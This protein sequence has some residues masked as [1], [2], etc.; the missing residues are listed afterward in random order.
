MKKQQKIEFFTSSLRSR[1][2]PVSLFDLAAPSSMQETLSANLRVLIVSPKALTSG[3]MCT[4]IN[5]FACPPGHYMKKFKI[6]LSNFF[7][8]KVEFIKKTYFFIFY[9]ESLVTLV[10]A[11]CFCKEYVCSSG[12]ERKW[13]LRAPKVICWCIALPLISRQLPRICPLFHFQPSP[14]DGGNLLERSR[15]PALFLGRALLRHFR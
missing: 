8:L 9:L 1:I 7:R 4:N 12:Q 15:K 6:K 14:Q 13:H 5:V 11:C 2:S 10:W 3:F